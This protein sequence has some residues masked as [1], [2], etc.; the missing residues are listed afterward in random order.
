[1]SFFYKLIVHSLIF[2]VIIL[3]LFRLKETTISQKTIGEIIKE[4]RTKYTQNLLIQG[5]GRRS[6]LVNINK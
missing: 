1:M 4:G 5:I 6:Y 3:D 2:I